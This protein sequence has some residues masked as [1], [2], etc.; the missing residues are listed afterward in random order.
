MVY[1]CA[2]DY[3]LCES[4]TKHI[5]ECID[6]G[7]LNKVSIFVN[8]DPV[9]PEEI[10]KNKDIALSLHLNLVEGR[11]MA[12]PSEVDLIA[13]ENG[14][15]RHTF[16]GL[17]KLG[18][19]HPKKLEEQAYKEIRAQV[20][21]WKSILPEGM[22]FRIDGHQHTHMIPSIFKAL[23]RVLEEEDINLK[24][25]RIP[26]EPL[27]PFITTPS[28]YFTYGA[29]NIIKQWTLNFLWMLNKHQAKK[30]HIHTSYFFG[31]LFSGKMDEDRVMKI[32][33]KYTRIAE[34]H[35]K[36]VEVLFHPGYSD[37]SG[38]EFSGK[39]VAFKHF[40]SS[41]NRKTEFDSVMKISKRSELHALHRKR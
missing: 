25:I 27:Y 6:A 26:A 23:V 22:P 41:D 15:L 11:C 38:N 36:D 12:D 32:L 28:L 24:H 39:N 40:Y 7:A 5:Q 31:I 10:E 9:D 3:G 34:K 17:F 20:L 8:F 14:N 18:L 30:H 13:D 35:G 4:T 29:V 2:D 37:E 19:L 33:P 1:I 21:S 16:G